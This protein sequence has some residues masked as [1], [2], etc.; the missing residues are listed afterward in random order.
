MTS[1]DRLRAQARKLMA[2]NI[3]AVSAAICAA[4]ATLSTPMS[5]RGVPI[6]IEMA[7]VGLTASWREEP[8]SA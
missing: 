7:E 4:R 6:S 5:A 2:A 8:N 3:T 1:D